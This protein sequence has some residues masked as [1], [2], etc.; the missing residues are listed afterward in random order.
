[1]RTRRCMAPP[2]P[3][4]ER[5]HRLPARAQVPPPRDPGSRAKASRVGTGIA[6]PGDQTRDA[7]LKTLRIAFLLCFSSAALAACSVESDGA[8]EGGSD[9]ARGLGKAD[10]VWGSCASKYGDACGGP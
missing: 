6:L 3:T 5:L 1:M 9:P 7:P 10:G 2:V 8:T 4:I